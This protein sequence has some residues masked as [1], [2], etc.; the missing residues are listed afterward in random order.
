MDSRLWTKLIT[1][2]FIFGVKFHKTVNR[3]QKILIKSF[4]ISYKAATYL[5]LKTSKRL[6]TS[7]KWTN[8]KMILL[9]LN[10]TRFSVS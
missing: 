2:R 3:T 8:V 7:I 6:S 4:F 10:L 1:I 5:I 9:E